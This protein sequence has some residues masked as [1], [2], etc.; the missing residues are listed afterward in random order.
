[1]TALEQAIAD[2]VATQ[3]SAAEKRILESLVADTDR[4]LSFAQACEYLSISDYTLR[5]LVKSKAIPHRMHG[6]EGSKNPRYLFS[7][8]SLN[9][10]KR[11]EEARNYRPNGGLST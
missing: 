5:K 6:A 10:W 11:D 7:S 2:I 9:Q 1:M 4:T 8:N 3:V